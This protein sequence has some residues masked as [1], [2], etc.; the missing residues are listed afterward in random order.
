MRLNLLILGAGRGTRLSPL[1]DVL[2]KPLLTI[3]NSE[4]ILLRMVKQFRELLPITN[5]WVNVSTH[6][7][8]FLN[9]LSGLDSEFRPQ[10][11]F[12][13]NLLGSANTIFELS[14][15]HN[16]PTLVI[17]GD[18]TLSNEY[19][20]ILFEKISRN[21]RF[22]V[23][24]HSRSSD[25]ARSQITRNDSNMV[26]SI[27]NRSVNSVVDSNVLVNSGIYFF[28]NLKQIGLAPE[29]GIEIADS[30]LQNLIR[31][32]KLHTFEIKEERVSVDSFKQ[33]EEARNL[34]KKERLH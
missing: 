18:L 13:P 33:L 25:S 26:T 19:V 20:K 32:G 3:G 6:P 23:F 24:C 11:L 15:V 21:P 5:I 28:P 16:G 9:Y 22:V 17:H 27:V 34:V 7:E 2:P 31:L 10:V 29:I 30:I 14:K 4:T 8:T 1:T 12:E